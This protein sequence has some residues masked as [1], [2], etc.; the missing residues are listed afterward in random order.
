MKRNQNKYI[1]IFMKIINYWKISKIVLTRKASEVVDKIKLN[2]NIFRIKE[3][4]TTNT[5]IL[6]ELW[7]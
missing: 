1:L 2:K 6:K 4:L 3:K 7:R 5:Q